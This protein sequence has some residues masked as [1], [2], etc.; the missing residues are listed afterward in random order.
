MLPSA[1]ED[2]EKLDLSYI[3]GGD[4]N[5]IATVENS[6]TMLYKT[7]HMLTVQSHSWVFTQEKWKFRFTPKPVNEYSSSFIC[8]SIKLETSQ[9]S[10]SGWMDNK[11]VHHTMEYFSAIKSTHSLHTTWMDHRALCWVRESQSQRVTYCMIPFVQHFKV[12]KL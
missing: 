12:T 10:F 2:V 7:K 8:N 3:A 1:G 9:M 5:G 4:V 11:L 6:V